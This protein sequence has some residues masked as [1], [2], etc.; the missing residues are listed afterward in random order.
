MQYMDITRLPEICF[1]H[2]Y[3]A[4]NYRNTFKENRETVEVT[5]VAEGE[6]TLRK[7]GSEWH[8]GPGDILCLI[9]DEDY[10]I[11]SLGYHAHR[12][13]C[14]RVD[15][16]ET[17]SE[18]GLVLPA[19]TP[20]G[21][22]TE[23][24]CR[25]IDD[26][27][28]SPYRHEGTAVRGGAA[29]LEILSRIDAIGREKSRRMPEGELLV[30]RAKRYIYRNLDR[31]ITQREIAA[32]LGITPQYLC[33]IFRQAEGKSLIRYVNTA[34]LKGIEAL[35][36][37]EHIRLYE[38]ARRFGYQDA[39]YVSGL[40]KKIFGRNITDRPSRNGEGWA[41]EEKSI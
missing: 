32:H 26:L 40:Y 6:L 22:G 24:V 9:H 31:P 37:K 36:E 29:F 11:F 7:G 38:A 2:A 28:W 39:N 19:V 14:A 20:A 35:M 4:S 41:D 15:W 13:V 16:V 5:F 1:A 10:E 3:S 33:N 30:R 25:L 23:A 18:N 12:T 17:E 21:E 34:K 8:A 27:I